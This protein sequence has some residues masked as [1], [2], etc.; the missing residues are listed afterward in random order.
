M[1][2]A[3]LVA[4][5]GLVVVLS[6]RCRELSA[7]YQRLRVHA[8]L[9]HAGTMVPTFR[10]AT[11]QGRPVVIGELA[12]STAR[13]VLFVFNTTCPFCRATVPVWQRM[14]DSLGRLGDVHVL[15]IFLDPLDSTEHYV[16][17]HAVR[18]QVV[19]FPQRKLKR[20][21]R[22][23]AVPQTVVLDWKGTVLYAKTGVLDSV[24]LD[25]VYA[26]VTNRSQR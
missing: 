2:V 4:A 18:Y 26:A 12:D 3:A 16:A 1:L 10:T 9:P 7:D 5:S 24:T 14:A 13:Q 22:A 17:T 8:T 21:Y 19:T 25:S 11:L 6:R 20:L 23:V 15:A